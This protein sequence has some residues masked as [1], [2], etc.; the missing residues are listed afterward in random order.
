MKYRYEGFNDSI[1]K[2]MGDAY[3][4]LYGLKP[5]KRFTFKTTFVRRNLLYSLLVKGMRAS[6]I[7]K[8][9]DKQM[10]CTRRQI[11]SDLRI[12]IKGQRITKDKFIYRRRNEA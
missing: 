4:M 7:W 3:K 1:H 10:P 11:I 6:M 5:I 12:M 9:V 8:L 2:I